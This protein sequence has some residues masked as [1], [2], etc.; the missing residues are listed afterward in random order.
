MCWEEAMKFIL[1]LLLLCATTL[2]CTAADRILMTRLGP[3]Q[4]SLFVSN[5]DGSGERV[6]TEGALDY[7]PAWSPDGQWIVFTS[8]RNGS[9][10]LYSVR[11]DGSGLERLTDNPAYNDQAAFSPDGSQIVFVTTRA[12]GTA[13]LWIL[14]LKTRRATPLTS[15]PGGNFRPAWSPD[16][17][18]IAFSSDRESS[19]P[20]A[21]GRWERLHL[22]DIYLARPDGSGLKRLSRHGDFCGNPKWSR[23][24]T[25]VVAYCMPAEDTWTYR[26]ALRKGGLAEEGETT[27]IR[28]DIAS[29]EATPVSAG[30]GVK[31]FPSVLPSGEVAYFRADGRAQ[32]VFYAGG[33]AGPAGEVRWPVWSPDGNR[34]VYGRDVSPPPGA[35]RKIWSR[36]SQYE[37]FSTG[38]LPAYD[39]SGK[40]YV[41]TALAA[42]RRDS[43]LTLT[44]G[45]GPVKKLLESKDELI[46]A[47]QWSPSGD[48]VIFGIGKFAAFLDFAIGAKK[49]VD[50]VNGGA[51]VAVI[52]VDGSG[53]RKITSG[54]NNNGFAAYA[55][56]GKR[57][58]YRT[59]GPDG[60]GLRVMNLED[61]AVTTLTEEYDN[62]P[63]WSPRGDLIAFVRRVDGDFEVFTIRPDG[64][65]LRRLTHSKGNEGHLAWSPDGEK[66]MFSSSRMGFKDEA[67]YTAAPQPYGDLFVMRYDGTQVEQLTD[68]QWEDA[69][70]A[71]QPRKD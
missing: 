58:V 10:D 47:P 56:D 34:I 29:G 31:I 67:L 48:A 32:G 43:T 46:I 20:T 59:M 51:Q 5:A 42:N 50:P 12:G 54:A 70:P 35:P 55:P 26:V 64:T 16:G 33:K 13:N 30:P 65:D 62:F 49:P 41:A 36:N 71:W 7:N 3:S 9:A 14:D 61:R 66:I 21:K 27:L 23:D 11:T 68:N 37:L 39:R 69:G 44:E 15:G 19:L 57:I 6:L 45:D 22:V 63:V 8:E 60:T 25:S 40:R 4:A 52:N 24:S 2:C 1:S 18:W 28:I 53:L 38:I 17:R